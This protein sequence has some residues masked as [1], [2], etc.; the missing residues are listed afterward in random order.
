M[1]VHTEL[2][3]DIIKTRNTPGQTKGFTLD[4]KM[5]IL[6]NQTRVVCNM[7]PTRGFEQSFLTWENMNPYIPMEILNGYSIL[8]K[9]IINPT[10]IS[11]IM[12]NY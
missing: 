9:F 5:M 8:D 4:Q 6:E 3:E 7:I 12:K 10:K 1:I 11:E 2:H